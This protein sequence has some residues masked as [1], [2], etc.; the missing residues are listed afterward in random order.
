[1][2]GRAIAESRVEPLAI[3]IAL[4]VSKQLALGLLAAGEAFPMNEL[5]LE[6]VQEALHRAQRARSVSCA[7]HVR[8]L[9]GEGPLPSLMAMKG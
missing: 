5:D 4:E 6:R 9:G 7:E 3:V 1:M 2:L 8:Q